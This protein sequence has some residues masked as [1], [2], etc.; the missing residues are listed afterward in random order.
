[1]RNREIWRM[2]GIFAAVLMILA[3][4]F[5]LIRDNAEQAKRESANQVS[6]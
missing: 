6:K 1:M 3:V 4:G 5:E 2:M